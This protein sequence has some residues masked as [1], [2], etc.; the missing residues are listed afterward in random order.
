M[1][2]GN[3]T[4]IISGLI[5][6]KG[7]IIFALAVLTNGWGSESANAALFGLF[8]MLSGGGLAALRAGVKKSGPIQLCERTHE[9][10]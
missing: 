5:F 1:L 7:L 6:L 8:E 2:G 4:Y 9:T 3:K 10:Q